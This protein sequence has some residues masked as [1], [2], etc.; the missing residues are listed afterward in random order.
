MSQVY[1]GFALAGLMFACS[2]SG[3]ADPAPVFETMPSAVTT[4][5]FGNQLADEGLVGPVGKAA[6][7]WRAASCLDVQV[8]SGSGTVWYYTEE[9]LENSLAGVTGPD[10]ENPLW[11]VMEHHDERM[12]ERVAVHEMGHRLGLL[13]DTK[14]VM[15]ENVTPMEWFIGEKTLNRLCSMRDCGCFNPEPDPDQCQTI[16]WTPGKGYSSSWAPCD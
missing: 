8:T 9:P 14:E 13:H 5:E 3:E 10:L 2:A 12:E 16:T 7:R 6:E 1:Y 15:V 4:A 11:V